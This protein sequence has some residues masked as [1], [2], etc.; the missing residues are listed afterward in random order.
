MP[1]GVDE[2]EML[3]QGIEEQ[4]SVQVTPLFKASLAT[5]A[6]MFCIAP[7]CTVDTV[8]E[9][10]TSG[11]GGAGGVEEPPEVVLLLLE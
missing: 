5:V 8:G 2:G 3:P 11:A 7:A 4:D 10:V 1:L 6:M 9:T